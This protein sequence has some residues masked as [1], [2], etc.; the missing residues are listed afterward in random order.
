LLE[1]NLLVSKFE[2]KK[3]EVEKNNTIKTAKQRAAFRLRQRRARAPSVP[4]RDKQIS[5][6]AEVLRSSRSFDSSQAFGVYFYRL[7]KI[8]RAIYN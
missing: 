3:R 8:C 2:F 7:K 6:S 5:D 4:A 1:N